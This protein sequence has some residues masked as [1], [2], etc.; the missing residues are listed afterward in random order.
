MGAQEG[1]RVDVH[2]S[3]EFLLEEDGDG[4]DMEFFQQRLGQYLEVFPRYEFLGWYSTGVAP[5]ETDH[6]LHKRLQEVSSNENPFCVLV[7]ADTL[8]NGQ[9]PGSE[10][11]PVKVY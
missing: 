8:A 9:A 11:L 4:P 6:M 3:F 7:D 10:E 5:L 2:N 1:R